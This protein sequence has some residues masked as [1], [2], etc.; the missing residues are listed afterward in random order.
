MS[1]QSIT[2]DTRTQL[3]AAWT[4]E[5]NAA[6]RDY[7]GTNSRE[8]LQ[9]KLEAILGFGSSSPSRGFGGSSWS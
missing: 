4:A 3:R 1:A 7:L 8:T 9:K 6:R 5:L 2:A